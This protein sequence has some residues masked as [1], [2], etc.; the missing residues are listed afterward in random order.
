VL[1]EEIIWEESPPLGMEGIHT[2]PRPRHVDRWTKEDIREWLEEV[3]LAQYGDRLCD[4]HSIDGETLLLLKEEDLRLPPLEIKVRAQLKAVDIELK[5]MINLW[6]V[7][8]FARFRESGSSSDE[9]GSDLSFSFPRHAKNLRPEFWKLSV[10]LA[11]FFLVSWVTSFTMVIVHDRVPD[12]TRH[13]PLPDIVLDNIPLI[14]WA[15][16]MS[17]I[18]ASVLICISVSIL[19]FHKHRFIILRRFFGLSGTVF[20]LRC[21]TM[22]ITSLSVPGDH[23]DCKARP[24]GDLG[25]KLHEASM[26]WRGA[27]MSIQGVR[28]CGDYMFS[29]HTVMLTMLNFFI[30]E[31][32]SRKFYFLHVISWLLNMFGVFFILAAHEHYSIDVFIAFYITSRL[33]LYYHTLANNRT[34]TQGH[35]TKTKVYF[36]MLSYFEGNVYGTVP[37][38]FEWPF[39]LSY[40]MSVLEAVFHRR[41]TNADSSKID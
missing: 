4:E 18:C 26:I 40:W 29:G 37:N 2:R 9:M 16:D 32:T 21:V 25:S 10:S 22:L 1:A 27:G 8:I 30:T 13:P 41:S 11:Y 34:F 28:T 24:A 20:L 6:N 35:S 38:E 19:V 5:F 23:L 14:P 3:G 7:S 39:S 17:E 33:F 36:P 31:Y 15:F 12:M